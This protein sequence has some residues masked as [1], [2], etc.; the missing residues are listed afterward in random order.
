MVS[1]SRTMI[2]I[3]RDNSKILSISAWTSARL[4]DLALLFSR[5]ARFDGLFRT[6]FF[7]R[8]ISA[9]TRVM[10][11]LPSN[12]FLRNSNTAFWS[13]SVTS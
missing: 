1:Q 4:V 13:M 2:C 11:I 12:L 5:M 7:P 8:E 6:D 10:M 9:L 3:D